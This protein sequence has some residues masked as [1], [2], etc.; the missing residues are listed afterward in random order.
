MFELHI[1]NDIA[2]WRYSRTT[3]LGKFRGRS[4]AEKALRARLVSH[5]Q[6]MS[7][8]EIVEVGA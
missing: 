8:Y 5:S 4:G 3:I 7:S 2:M 6:C 1:I